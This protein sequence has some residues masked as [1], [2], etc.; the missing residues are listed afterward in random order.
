MFSNHAKAIVG[1]PYPVDLERAVRLMRL[2]E[3]ITDWE[4]VSDAW[5]AQ[6]AWCDRAEGAAEDLTVE[7]ARLA[8]LLVETNAAALAAGEVAEASL[9]LRRPCRLLWA[10]KGGAVHAAA[11]QAT[12]AVVTLDP[13]TYQYQMLVGPLSTVVAELREVCPDSVE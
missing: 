13:E 10:E 4:P 1:T 2:I 7:L 8:G 5:L 11:W 3:Q 12:M 9:M 6:P